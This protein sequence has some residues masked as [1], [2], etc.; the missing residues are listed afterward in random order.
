MAALE[1]KTRAEQAAV[2]VETNKAI[3]KT[4]TEEDM[5]AFKSD[6]DALT[7]R[8]GKIGGKTAGNI[9][10]AAITDGWSTVQSDYDAGRYSA[11]QEKITTLRNE[12]DE[13]ETKVDEA[14]KAA[15]V[16]ASKMKG[17]GKKK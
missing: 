4:Q 15:T 1:A 10:T 17:K 5:T 6:F 7:L 12:M 2:A 11:V 16:A 14:E 8:I 9:K 3:V 13:L